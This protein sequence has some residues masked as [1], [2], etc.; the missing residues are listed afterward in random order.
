MTPRGK[1]CSCKVVPFLSQNPNPDKII[2]G[3]KVSLGDDSFYR[4]N[5]RIMQTELKMVVVV[6]DEVLFDKVSHIT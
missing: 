4:I 1:C 6:V 5:L 2:Y 3:L